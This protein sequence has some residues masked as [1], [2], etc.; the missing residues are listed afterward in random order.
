MKHFLCLAVLSLLSVSFT[1]TAKATNC[2][3]VVSISSLKGV[4]YKP[5][6]LHG[7]RGPTFLVQNPFERTNK[8]S[9]LIKDKSCKTI[10]AFGLYATDFPYGARY[11][12]RARGGKGHSDK[13]LRSLSQNS[14]ILVEGRNGKWIKI[15]NPTRRQGSVR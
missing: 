6:N 7:G 11:Y 14:F 4:L 12:Q 13:K 8:Q 5:S 2:S 3:N 15:N 9:V 10:S 1:P